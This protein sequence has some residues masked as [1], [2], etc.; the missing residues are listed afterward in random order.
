MKLQLK[1]VPL[2]FVCFLVTLALVALVGCSASGIHGVV[3][4]AANSAPL[5]DVQVSA[6]ELHTSTDAKG[7]FKLDLPLGSYQVKLQIEGYVAQMSS[8]SL[9]QKTRQSE[10]SAVMQ[11]RVITGSITE[12]AKGPLAGVQVSMGTASTTTDES[13]QF[14]LDAIQAGSI[15]ISKPGYL[16][17]TLDTQQVSLLFDADGN[18][19]KPLTQ[20]LLPRVISG[21]VSEEGTGAPIADASIQIGSLKTSTNQEGNYQLSY[22]ELGQ[23]V[24]I[25]SGAYRIPAGILYTGQPTLDI[26]LKPYQA[27]VGISDA[28]SGDLLPEATLTSTAGTIS[29]NAEGRF[30]AR[31][32]PGT[33]LTASLTGYRNAA[34]KYAGEE[35]LEIKLQPAQLVGQIRASDSGQPISGA[36][37]LAYTVDPEPL[38]LHSDENGRFYYA[39]DAKVEKIL[40]RVPGYERLSLPITKTGLIRIDLA[41]FAAKALYVPF[42]LLYDRAAFEGILD[43]IK[44]TEANAIVVDLKDDWATTAWQSNLPLAI[45]INA[46]NKHVMDA[47]DIIKLAHE[48]GIYVIGRLVVFKDDL[49]ATA[50]PEYAVK[51]RS[52]GYYVDLEGLMWVDPFR[53]EVQD[54]N[55]GLALELAAMGIDEVQYDYIRFPSDG[56]VEGLLYSQEANYESRTS[57]LSD[58]IGRTHAALMKTPTFFSVDVFG[59]VPWVEPGNDMGIGQTMEGIAPNVDYLCPMLYPT[60]FGPGELGYANPGI[61]PYEI[62]YRTVMEAHKRSTVKVRPWLQHYTIFGIEYGPV[63]RLQQRKAADDAGSSGWTYWNAAGWYERSSIEKDVYAKYPAVINS[64]PDN[65]R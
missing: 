45:E 18:L 59:L 36:V 30:L 48:R 28:E 1:S 16:S 41:P 8:I 27:L 47:K 26:A 42:G 12:A 62:I 9:D 53:K 57:A 52:G 65:M 63:E 11:H 19:T 29:R 44:D 7:Q 2:V 51:R 31:M 17:A 14:T 49:L 56:S 55:I 24:V 22:V 46:Y 4:D 23:Q 60:T 64:T 43:L 38:V 32:L 37:I 25:Q 3:T 6:G 13:G 54:Y 20:E 5:A 50:Y 39:E 15:A 10:L 34:M 61:Y 35:T 33:V 40:V 21:T 58:F